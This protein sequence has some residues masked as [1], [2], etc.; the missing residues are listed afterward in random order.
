MSFMAKRNPNRIH[1]L[2]LRR[3]W[4]QPELAERVGAHWVTI[5]KLERGQMQLTH[6]WM[7]RI[8]EALE[9][10][11]EDLISDSS[12]VRAVYMSG[13][14]DDRGR[15]KLLRRHGETVEIG[16]RQYDVQI[17]SE[18]S[19]ASIWLLIETDAYYP[20]IH[21]GDIVRFT[22]IEIKKLEKCIGRLC[23]IETDGEKLDR[24]VGIV[25][26]GNESGTIDVQ[27]PGASPLQGVV[28]ANI[29][30]AS[31]ALFEPRFVDGENDQT[32]R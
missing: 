16:S 13:H 25:S 7:V 15:V 4:S 6:E 14:L 23:F 32:S 27:S 9:I 31:M 21:S 28:P 29:A 2:R 22:F 5:S 8:A 1:E 3:K 26:R 11:P 10:R 19:E 18:S 30:I 24:F 12:L 17:G 20:L